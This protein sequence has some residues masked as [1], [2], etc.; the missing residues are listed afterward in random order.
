MPIPYIRSTLR[1][2]L[3][4]NKDINS[5]KLATNQNSKITENLSG[6]EVK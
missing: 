5:R 2:L 4:V 3:A 6:N 1:P